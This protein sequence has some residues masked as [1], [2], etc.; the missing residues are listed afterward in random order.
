MYFGV[1]WAPV[2]LYGPIRLGVA[3]MYVG[4]YETTKNTEVLKGAFPFLTLEWKDF[5]FNVPIIPPLG[6][7]PGVVALQFKYRF[8]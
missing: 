3:A 5:G 8:Q 2:Q 7:N 1:A 4:G 6:E